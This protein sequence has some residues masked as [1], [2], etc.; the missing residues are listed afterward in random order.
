MLKFFI[1]VSKPVSKDTDN[2]FGNDERADGLF[3]SVNYHPH[4]SNPEAW[5]RDIHM[6]QQAGFRVVRLGHLAWDSY[7]P[8]DGQFNFTWF[9]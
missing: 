4:D 6:M 8:K 5:T 7:E 1:G 9:D 2:G 3:V